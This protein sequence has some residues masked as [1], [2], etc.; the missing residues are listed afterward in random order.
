MPG[1]LALV[2]LG[3]LM[4]ALAGAA[5]L[6]PGRWKGSSVAS[7]AAGIVGALLAAAGALPVLLGSPT[8]SWAWGA[9]PALRL[10]PLAALLICAGSIPGA[11]ASLYRIGSTVAGDPDRVGAWTGLFLA[12]ILLT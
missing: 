12:A 2:L 4:H 10:D 6:A 5:A 8:A 11:A 3:A 1:S 7:G 9:S